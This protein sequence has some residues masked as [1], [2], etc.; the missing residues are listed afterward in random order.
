MLEII[1]NI[2]RAL[3]P[4]EW[5][6]HIDK[7]FGNR[8]EEERL[9]AQAKSRARAAEMIESLL[10]A[11]AIRY[12]KLTDEEKEQERITKQAKQAEQRER[13]ARENAYWEE[14]E[15]DRWNNP[16]PK[17]EESILANPFV[18]IAGA[19]GVANA[20]DNAERARKREWKLK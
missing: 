10:K 12:S 18:L 11:E 3:C 4:M 16:P 8:K 20:L 17:K 5:S 7:L 19:I 2:L 15:A 6:V 13:D 1:G 14:L 9:R